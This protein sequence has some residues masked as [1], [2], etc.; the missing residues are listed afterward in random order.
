MIGIDSYLRGLKLSLIDIDYSSNIRPIL[1]PAEFITSSRTWTCPISGMYRV[2]AVGAGGSGS[3]AFCN[4][5]SAPAASGGGG[6]GFCEKNL[7][8]NA[9]QTLSIV[10][11]AGGAGVTIGSS[12]YGI[13]GNNGGNSTVNGTN[14]SL[15]AYGGSKGLYGIGTGN[16]KLG[17]AGGS[18]SGG[19][20]NYSGGS[21]GSA[22]SYMASRLFAAGGGGAPGSPYGIGGA[23][24]D[25]ANGAGGGG[26][27]GGYKGG[28][29]T[30][31]NW[32]GGA[33]TGS[34]G[35][36]SVGGSNRLG[37]PLLSSADGVL[38]AVFAD[39]SNWGF[40]TIYNPLRSL[41]GGGGAGNSTSYCGPGAG[42]GAV[43]LNVS[44]PL[45]G[46]GGATAYAGAITIL[47]NEP[48]F[49]GGGSGGS[50]CIVTGPA[51][52]NRAGNG[53]VIIELIGVY[54]N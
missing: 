45:F 35:S 41:S 18:A 26:A 48:V 6:G 50:S 44:G 16:T 27:V 3:A 47:P 32:G 23:G 14:I 36:G 49:F 13:D 4:A 25:G 9:S 30:G 20:I 42:T 31:G 22:Y 39:N 43:G 53:L 38:R 19:D 21:G 34:N 46:G 37:L 54:V 51:K 17:G 2:S 33:G 24:G 52:S 15:T 8:I 5:T 40:E 7:I 10:V 12:P 1:S 28:D 29:G 11:G